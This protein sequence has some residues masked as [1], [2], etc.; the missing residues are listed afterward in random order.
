MGVTV[1][2]VFVAIHSFL[3]HTASL[4]EFYALQSQDDQKRVTSAYLDRISGNEKERM[5]GVKRVDFLMGQ[6]R[7]LGLS[8]MGMERRK[9]ITF[10][11]S[12]F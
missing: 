12:F 11:V 6:S 4:D 8:E 1:E 10:V 9:P 7:F 3:D 2:D 5:M